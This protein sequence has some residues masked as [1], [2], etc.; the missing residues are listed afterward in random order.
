[1]SILEQEWSRTRHWIDAA[2]AHSPGLETLEDVERLLSD[3]R[4]MLWTSERC[5]A[6]TEI[7]EYASRKV[8]VIVHAGGDKAELINEMEPRIAEFG[9]GQ[10]CDMIAVTGRHGWQREGERHGYRLGFVTMVKDLKQ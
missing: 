1:M 2:L 4:Y 7:A 9:V 6:V 5:A 3:G 10:G 8:I